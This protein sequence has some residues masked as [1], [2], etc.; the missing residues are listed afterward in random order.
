MSLYNFISIV[1]VNSEDI[2]RG[3]KCTIRYSLAPLMNN[4]ST[5]P[6]KLSSFIINVATYK[7]EKAGK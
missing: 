2:L 4:Y 5:K 3:A 6:E 7:G 1:Y